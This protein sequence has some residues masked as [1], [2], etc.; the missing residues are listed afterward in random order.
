MAIA[1]RTL[2]LRAWWRLRT[3]HVPRTPER[4]ARVGSFGFA[5]DSFGRNGA[6]PVLLIAGFGQQM[7]GWDESFCA[8]LAARGFRVIRYDHRNIGRSGKVSDPPAAGLIGAWS[9]FSPTRWLGSLAG[10]HPNTLRDM[11]ED[12][13]GLL[14]ALG[15]DSA[16]VVGIS[17][18]GM[19]AQL[20]AIHHPARVRTL[21]SISS[22]T[23]D[24]LIGRP[25][26][27]ALWKLLAPAPHDSDG[28]AEHAAELWR[29]L[30]TTDDAF[31]DAIERRRARRML[32]RGVSPEALRRQ[33][34][35]VVR[36]RS[37]KSALALVTSPAL[38][39]HG[40]RDPLVPP[41]AGKDTADAIPGAKL[42]LLADVGHALPA[43]SWHRVVGAIGQHA[44]QFEDAQATAR[45]PAAP[46]RQ[47]RAKCG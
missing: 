12:A 27:S 38:V 32:D 24:P 10:D 35:A 44:K 29:L 18:G 19:I 34:S 25:T 40:E 20:L 1:M 9:R 41:A 6:P 8:L 14:A 45:D 3:L 31:E 28:F 2:L 26:Q 13:A 22:T 5:Y 46:S 39:I 15:I 11:A 30:R 37:W 42:L 4:I 47:P 36:S 23:G 33:L 7:I 21:T 17:M 43:S 16:H